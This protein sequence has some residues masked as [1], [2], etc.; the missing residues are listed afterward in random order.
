MHK[1]LISSLLI[2]CTLG[3]CST[4]FAEEIKV[5]VG[6]QGQSSAMVLPSTGMS[7][8]QV[9]QKFGEPIEKSAPVGTPPIS[10]WK[11]S[12]YTVYFEYDH[13]IHAVRNFRRQDAP[14]N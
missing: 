8:A 3:F 11:Y 10:K 9:E 1:S 5:P 7:K 12:D 4:S 6:E 13:V 2:L 14:G